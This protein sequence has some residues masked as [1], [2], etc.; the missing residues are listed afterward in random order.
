VKGESSAGKSMLVR[1]TLRLF[2][3]SAYWGLTAMSAKALI[4]TAEDFSHRYIV[5]YEEVVG[6]EEADY[7]VRTLQSEGCI[8]YARTSQLLGQ[9]P[10]QV[11][12]GGV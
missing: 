3:Q 11:S 2:P 9:S 7:L 1:T 6:G 5:I 8:R 4:F 10:T 12:I